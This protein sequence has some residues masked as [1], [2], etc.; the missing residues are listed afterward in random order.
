MQMHARTHTQHNTHTQHIHTL[1]HF[2]TATGQTSVLRHTSVVVGQANLA[3]RPSCVVA[4]IFA[5]A[6]MARLLVQVTVKV[7]PF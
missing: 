2:I 3:V 1:T 4:A 7:T 6:P 5:V